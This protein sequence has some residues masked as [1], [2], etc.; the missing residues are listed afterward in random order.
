MSTKDVPKDRPDILAATRGGENSVGMDDE[1]D[2]DTATS[3]Q[4]LFWQ[5][6]YREILDMEEA[7]LARVHQLM[8]GQS[9]QAQREV[10][11]TNL[12][13]IVAQVERFRSRMGIWDSRVHASRDNEV[14]ACGD[15]PA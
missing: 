9:P 3:E 6:I 1:A 7:V 14:P 15:G 5:N 8:A 4:A 10:E 2:P 13:V 11:L 12:P